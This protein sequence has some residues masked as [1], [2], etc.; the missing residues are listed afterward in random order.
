LFNRAKP[1]PQPELVVA[2]PAVE[3]TAIDTLAVRRNAVVKPVAENATREPV[4]VDV[5]LQKAEYQTVSH[6]YAAMRIG[7]SAL[8]KEPQSIPEAPDLAHALAEIRGALRE[9]ERLARAKLGDDQSA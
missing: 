6:S 8:E 7:A 9:H 4:A 5:Q 3:K 1:T 2:A